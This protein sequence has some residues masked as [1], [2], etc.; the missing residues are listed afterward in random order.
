ML[1]APT[2]SQNQL[3]GK[4]MLY[5]FI[6]RS[7]RGTVTEHNPSW[8]A[9]LICKDSF[10]KSPQEQ[11]QGAMGAIQNSAEIISVEGV[12]IGMAVELVVAVCEGVE[13]G[14]R[15]GVEVGNVSKRGVA[16]V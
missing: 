3:S 13:G 9:F 4:V 14:M 16:T 6:S 7:V 2:I 11:L 10:D 15:L 5:P 1:S 12:I 8:L